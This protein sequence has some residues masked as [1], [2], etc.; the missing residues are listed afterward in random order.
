MLYMKICNKHTH[1]TRN[2]IHETKLFETCFLW[3]S[4][5]K[6]LKSKDILNEFQG[7]FHHA[8]SENPGLPSQKILHF[9]FFFFWKLWDVME[10]LQFKDHHCFTVGPRVLKAIKKIKMK[11]TK[12]REKK[13][14]YITVHTMVKPDIFWVK[15]KNK[16]C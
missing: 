2:K 16:V 1:Y 7:K 4:T 10:Q 12:D 8:P 11:N 15:E 5:T 3:L 9:F 13:I 14:S 6:N